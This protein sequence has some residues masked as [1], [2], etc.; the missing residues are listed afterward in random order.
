MTFSNEV[1]VQSKMMKSDSRPAPRGSS[2]HILNLWPIAGNRSDNVLK[3]TSVLQSCTISLCQST[4]G[5]V[6]TLGE[7]LDL[8]RLDWHT[9]EPNNAF[10]DNG[11]AHCKQ[12]HISELCNF[13]ISRREQFLDR[14]LQNLE[15]RNHH[16]LYLLVL[17][18]REGENFIRRKRLRFR[19]VQVFFGQ[20]EIENEVSKL[21]VVQACW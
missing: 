7:G 6:L 20:L 4:R 21:S 9:A 16:N 1:E 15:E 5:D 14:L 3:K 10:D 17:D 11:C 13:V 8:S 12:S 19:G 2:H 18:N